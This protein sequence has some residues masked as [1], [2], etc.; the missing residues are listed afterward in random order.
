MNTMS[1]LL[2]L[3]FCLGTAT[4]QVNLQGIVDLHVHCNPDSNPPRKIDAF[5][6]ARLF[7]QEGL[8]AFV[9]QSH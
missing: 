2:A 8:R 3:I 1:F 5:E 9:I 6:V 4:A 7:R